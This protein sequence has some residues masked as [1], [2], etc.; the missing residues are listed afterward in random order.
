[1]FWLMLI[2]MF[3][4][5]NTTGIMLFTLAEKLIEVRGDEAGLLW[6]MAILVLNVASGAA[7]WGAI[8]KLPPPPKD[9]CPYEP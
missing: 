6:A 5:M 8:G 3:V 7:M 2:A 1:M 9:E 4:W